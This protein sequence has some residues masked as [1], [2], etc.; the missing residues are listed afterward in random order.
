MHYTT[1]AY[2]YIINKHYKPICVFPLLTMHIAIM[3]QNEQEMHT[4]SAQVQ[5]HMFYNL[6]FDHMRYVATVSIFK[7]DN[8]LFQIDDYLQQV[9][10]CCKILETI[11]RQYFRIVNIC[12]T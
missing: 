11:S 2:I 10:M 1:D 9:Q 7:C 5:I 4:D 3:S 6:D 12:L 8:I